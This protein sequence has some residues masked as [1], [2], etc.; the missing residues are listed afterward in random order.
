MAPTEVLRG[1]H[2]VINLSNRGRNYFYKFPNII[3][4]HIFLGEPFS[5][6]CGTSGKMYKM[7]TPEG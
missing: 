5:A 3:F 4:D 2:H 1:V 6:L 7:A